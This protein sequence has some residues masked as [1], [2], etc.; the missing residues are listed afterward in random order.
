MLPGTKGMGKMR[1]HCKASNYPAALLAA[2]ADLTQY[3][4]WHKSH[5]LPLF[6]K[7]PEAIRALFDTDIEALGELVDDLLFCYERLKREDEIPKV[8]VS[9]E[10][11]ARS[12]IWTQKIT[13]FKAMH[14]LGRGWNKDAGLLAL[15]TLGNLDD[16]EDPETL[17]LYL[18]LS[19]DDLSLSE[20]L[21]H[22]DRV[23]GST[24]NFS[25]KTH[26]MT[27]RAMKLL[28]HNDSKG[29]VLGFRDVLK[30]FDE[31]G[32][33]NDLDAFQ[34]NKYCQSLYMFGAINLD[35]KQEELAIHSFKLSIEHFEIM[36]LNENFT[37]HG[38]SGIYRDIGDAYRLMDKFKNAIEAYDRSYAY[39]HNAIILVFRASCLHELGKTQKALE[40]IDTLSISDFDQDDGKADFVIHYSILAI[41]SGDTSR[42]NKAKVLLDIPIKRAPIF[43][44]QAQRM[45]KIVLEALHSGP[46]EELNMKARLSIRE[47]ILRVNSYLQLQPNIMGIGIDLNKII[48]DV[49]SEKPRKVGNK[50]AIDEHKKAARLN[51]PD[52]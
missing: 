23:I 41:A 5:T 9:L 19:V 21:K 20:H 35:F 37:P 17:A 39:E 24:E 3:T 50:L 22:I 44:Q 47:N 14:A 28:T 1:E 2:R 4:I 36:L 46:S 49:F 51:P 32:D 42:L 40:L 15:Q 45:S 25:T 10:P 12:S 11:N 52:I 29:A 27:M 43:H 7:N 26:Q 31:H 33:F 38:R 13:Y 18:N 34:Q 16:V 6:Q 48:E 8:L 30:V